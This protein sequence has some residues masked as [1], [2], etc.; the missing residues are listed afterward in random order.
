MNLKEYIGTL[1]T[2]ESACYKQRI[3]IDRL[4]AE[5]KRASNPTFQPLQKTSYLQEIDIFS[6]IIY[7]VGGALVGGGI[8]IAAAILV[9]IISGILFLLQIF[10]GVSSLET[11]KKIY[12]TNVPLLPFV[13]GGAVIGL[14][15]DIIIIISGISEC[16]HKKAENRRIVESN[17]R[18]AESTHIRAVNLQAELD[19]AIP[20]YNQTD[21]ILKQ[22]YNEGIIYKKYQE[23]VPIAMFYEYFAS[24]RCFRLD[25]HEGAYNLYE[26]ELRMNLILNKLDD[27]LYSLDQIQERQ[28]ML[29]N[30]IREGNATAQR[31]YQSIENCCDQLQD[32]TEN[33]ES[34]KYFA[35]VSAMNTTYMVWRNR[36]GK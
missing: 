12:E 34:A 13:I 14:I 15:C 8:G 26:Q 23:F 19:R 2:L 22:L 33:T 30:A 1:Y 16:K 3:L 18:R 9:L 29:A 5:L 25:G 6:L 31:I 32:I 20:L 10:F 4:R 7:P 24:G 21:A 28:Y 11:I 27:I 17:Q 35:Q 36:E